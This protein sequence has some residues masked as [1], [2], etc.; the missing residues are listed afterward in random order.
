MEVFQYVTFFKHI[1]FKFYVKYRMWKK[2]HKAEKEQR[3]L[4]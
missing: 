2:N 4:H 1:N 3:S